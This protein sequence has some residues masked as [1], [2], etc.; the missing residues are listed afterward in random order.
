MEK[1]ERDKAGK[2]MA[3]YRLLGEIGKGATSRVYRVQGA[4][5]KVYALKH[6]V[7]PGRLETEAEILRGLD[8]PCFPKW[9]E[10]GKLADGGYLVMEYVRGI[11]LSRLMEGYPEGMP[12]EMAL[13]IARDVTQGLAYLHGCQPP[14]IYRD[15]KADN[16]MVASEGRARLVDMGTAVRMDRRGRERRAGTYGYGAPEQFWEGASVTPACDLYALG[17]LL[18]YLLTGQDPCKPPYDTAL[19]CDRHSAIR[20]GLK[21]LLNR[22]LQTDP[23]LRYPDASFL[24][25]EIEELRLKKPGLGERI[26]T[27]RGNKRPYRYIKCIWRSEYERIF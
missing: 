20:G 23:Q 21:R 27:L 22:C 17:K 18:S 19:Y 8:H 1:T 9:V 12:E 6:S 3:G 14:Y 11:T 25:R 2:Y 15:L 13:G 16:V 5:G 10:D 24:L 26:R 4:D 7:F